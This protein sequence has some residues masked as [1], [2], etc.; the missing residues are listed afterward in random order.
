MD[1]SLTSPGLIKAANDALVQATPD[2]NVIRLF[3]YDFSDDFAEFGY[4]VK[5]PIVASGAL[6][7]EFGD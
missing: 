3:S 5:V 1:T 4:T 2:L 6:S 7:S